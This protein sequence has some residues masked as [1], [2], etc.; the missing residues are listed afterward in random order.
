M[1]RGIFWEASELELKVVKMWSR[2]GRGRALHRDCSRSESL[3]GRPGQG[4]EGQGGPEQA[5]K[6]EESTPEGSQVG[7]FTR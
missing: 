7:Y 2:E 6:S 3:E 5:E 4:L 1:L